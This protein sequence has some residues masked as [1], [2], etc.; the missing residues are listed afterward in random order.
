M[1][2]QRELGAPP[3]RLEAV[4]QVSNVLRVFITYFY[5]EKRPNG[6]IDGNL[7]TVQS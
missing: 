5:Y 6:S 1:S 4:I 3:P 7:M 2:S